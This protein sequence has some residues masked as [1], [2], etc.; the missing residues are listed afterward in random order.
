MKSSDAPT[1]RLRART[2]LFDLYGDYAIEGGRSGSLAVAAAVRLGLDL[3]LAEMATRSAMNRMARD[4]WLVAQRQGRSSVYALTQRGRQLVDAGRTRIFAAADRS[5]AGNWCV[6]ALSV[7][8][9]HREVRDRMRLGL[10]W[11]GF[12]SP[13]SSL[14]ISPHDHS[15]EVLRIASEMEADGYVQVYQAVLKWPAARDLVNRAW[16][17]LAQVNARYAAFLN[18]FTPGYERARAAGGNQSGWD[19]EAFKVRL[20]L[21]SEFRRCLFGDPALPASLLPAAWWSDAARRLF[22]DY[23][24]LL[25][26]GAMRH[27]DTVCVTHGRRAQALT[28]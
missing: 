15:K 5:W 1:P 2:L 8:E 3:G 22:L 20:M 11:L 9:S 28:A 7:P 6:V 19:V 17:D 27:F 14:Y 23:H 24:A 10:S 4:G 21:A 12:G 26:P 13:S 16:G 18:D 25:T